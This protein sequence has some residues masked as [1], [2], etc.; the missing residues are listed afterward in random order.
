MDEH[1]STL[2]LG[3]MKEQQMPS[4][5]RC[6]D[7]STL[8]KKIRWAQIN[9]EPGCSA[10]A[11]KFPF[12][13]EV[14]A[15]HLLG[16]APLLQKTLDHPLPEL[17]CGKGGG[18]D[19]ARDT[20]SL[21]GGNKAKPQGDP[22]AARWKAMAEISSYTGGLQSLRSGPDAGEQPAGTWIQGLQYL[23]GCPRPC[24]RQSSVS[25]REH[26]WQQAEI[27]FLCFLLSYPPLLPPHFSFTDVAGYFR[28]A[29]VFFSPL[30]FTARNAAGRLT[31]TRK[32]LGHC[33]VST[34]RVSLSFLSSP[35]ASFPPLSLPLWCV[36]MGLSLSLTGKDGFQGW[37]WVRKS[38]KSGQRQEEWWRVE[39]SAPWSD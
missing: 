18:E 1:L 36:W 14:C 22:T 31:C 27:C 33:L 24:E 26:A 19:P 16:M 34:I 11:L 13:T 35:T 3:D 23:H 7:I 4:V 15:W 28:F 20:A 32:E 21:W 29:W 9:C 6:T 30:G 2:V 39:A 25:A 37:L 5:S 38:H 17:P 8:R 12:E 10:W